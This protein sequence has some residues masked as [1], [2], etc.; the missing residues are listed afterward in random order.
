VARPKEKSLVRVASR[1]PESRRPESVSG[2]WTVD[3]ETGS[4][5]IVGRV[6]FDVRP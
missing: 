2:H 6:A 4:G 3:V 5:Q 1:L